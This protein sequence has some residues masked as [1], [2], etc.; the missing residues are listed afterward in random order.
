[1]SNTA[2]TLAKNYPHQTTRVA[3]VDRLPAPKEMHGQFLRHPLGC[4]GYGEYVQLRA[5]L[6]TLLDASARID[7]WC[8]KHKWQPVGGKGSAAYCLWHA[9]WKHKLGRKGTRVRV[10]LVGSEQVILEYVVT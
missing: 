3:N 1:M 5:K 4:T 10:V 6:E 7:I 2:V 8:G 9:F